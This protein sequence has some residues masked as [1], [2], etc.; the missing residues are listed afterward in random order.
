MQVNE[1]AKDVGMGANFA[2]TNKMLS[3]FAHPTAMQIMAP[4]GETGRLTLQKRTVCQSWMSVL[5]RRV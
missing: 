1:A 2:V 3:K 4:A 5:Q